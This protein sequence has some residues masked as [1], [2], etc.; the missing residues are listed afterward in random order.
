MLRGLRS[1][2]SLTLDDIQIAQLGQQAERQYCG[3]QCGIMDQMAASLGDSEHLLFLDTRTLAY[4]RLPLPI[5]AEI[6]VIDSGI[7]RALAASG[8]NQRR[9]ECESAAKIMGVNALRDISNVE[10]IAHLPPPLLARAHHVITENNRVLTACQGISA[11]QFGELM[12]ASH[13]SL[14][15]DYRVSVPALDILVNILQKTEGVF[16]AKLTGAGFGG[17]CVALVE[18]QKG[19]AI[20]A[21]IVQAYNQAGND[22]RILIA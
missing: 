17:S 19:R 8:Y 20:A 22:G 11:V 16:G 9:T 14:R 12:N 6:I 21:Q 1:L 5:G 7:P 3:V 15:D 18:A 4:Q 13:T 2:L 10:A